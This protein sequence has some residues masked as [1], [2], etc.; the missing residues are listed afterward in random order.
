MVLLCRLA[1]PFHGL[2]FVFAH[3][4]AELINKAKV[5]LRCWMILCGSLVIPLCGS[6]PV[7]RHSHFSKGEGIAQITLALRVALF[8]LGANVCQQFAMSF[9]RLDRQALE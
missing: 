9:G 3:A 5:E 2:G 7:L 4:I 1:I 8:R 6:S